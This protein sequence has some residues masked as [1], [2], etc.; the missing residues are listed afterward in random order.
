MAMSPNKQNKF[1]IQVEPVE[2]KSNQ[3]SENVRVIEEKKEVNSTGEGGGGIWAS[4]RDRNLLVSTTRNFQHLSN[5][6]SS[7]IKG[8]NWACKSGPLCKEP[9]REVKAKLV[10]L[11]LSSNSNLHGPTQITRAVSRAI[12]GSFLT[13]EP[14]LL[15]PVY[16]IE[17]TVPT[18]WFGS[19]ARVMTRKRG[20]IRKTQQKGALTIITGYIPV[21]ETFDLSQEMRSA[22]SGYAFWQLAFDHWERTPENLSLRIVKQLRKKRGLPAEIP[23]PETFVDEI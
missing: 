22:T 7:I 11:E 12:L 16:N 10:D 1:W 21:G 20:K 4:D 18:Q 15:E 8:F 17:V 2:S 6:K 23:R 19:C 13:G 9:M 3:L 5:E 14:I